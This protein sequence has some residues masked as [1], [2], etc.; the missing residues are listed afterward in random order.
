MRKTMT[1]FT[2][3]DEKLKEDM[4]VCEKLEAN[5]GSRLYARFSGITEQLERGKECRWHGAL[6]IRTE[7]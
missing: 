3:L 4:S 2:F 1:L 5:Y 7:F 6:K